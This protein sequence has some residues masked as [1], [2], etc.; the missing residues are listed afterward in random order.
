M[1]ILLVTSIY[2][3]PNS[4]YLGIF[5]QR[6]VAYLNELGVG[7][8]LAVSKYPVRQKF[9]R[10]YLC[11]TFQTLKRMDTAYDL[12]HVHWPV[13]P[14]VL[15]LLVARIC[16]CPLV[17]SVHG[18]E[19]DPSAI[20]DL[21]MGGMKRKITR[22]IAGWVMR[23]ADHVIVVGSYLT[24]VARQM[25]I[26]QKKIAVI[27]MGIDTTIFKPY[28]KTEA[29]T[30]LKLKGSDDD[31]IILTVASLVPVKGHTYL[32]KAMA[33]ILEQHPSCRLCLVGSGYLESELKNLS[34]QLGIAEHVDF[35]GQRPPD[36]IPW[37]MSVADVVV[38]PSLTES[39][40]LVAAEAAA[41]GTPVVAS[42]VGG[43]TDHVIEGENGFFIP[44]CDSAAIA[45]KVN[46]L[47]SNPSL[48]DTMQSRCVS[49]AR[50]HDSRLQAQKVLSLYESLIHQ[51]S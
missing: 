27:N 22:F 33:M 29:R 51:S 36:E 38:V 31:L 18:G 15:G 30:R 4:P 24:A 16:H 11:L 8:D 14:G 26:S 6:Q 10:K 34:S 44:P 1:R 28:L 3:S 45:R 40:G 19:I 2:P 42:G 17:V 9:L 25:G 48:L 43:L 32:L 37:W 21:K 46:W 39:F 35:A 50:K 20:W 7:V 12:V 5:V 13:F 41:C 23:R 49:S 47:F